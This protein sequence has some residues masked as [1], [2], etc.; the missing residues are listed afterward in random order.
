LAWSLSPDGSV[1]PCKDA[2]L[3]GV[4]GAIMKISHVEPKAFKI[5]KLGKIL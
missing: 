1:D 4:A 5:P 3:A 2:G